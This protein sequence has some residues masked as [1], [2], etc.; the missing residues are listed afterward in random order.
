MPIFQ[1][2]LTNEGIVFSDETQQTSSANPVGRNRIINGQMRVAQRGAIAVPLT[3][4]TFGGCD[5]FPITATGFTTASGTLRQAGTV[6]AYVQEAQMTTTGSGIVRFHHRIEAANV[7]DLHDCYISAQVEVYQNTGAAVSVTLQLTSPSEFVDNWSSWGPVVYTGTPS[8]TVSVP[9]G[10]R[11]KIIHYLLLDEYN[12]LG[13]DTAKGLGITVSFP[14]GAVTS[15]FFQ[16]GNVQLEKGRY[17]T[18]LEYVPLTLEQMRCFRYYDEVVVTDRNYASGTTGI[19]G[20]VK[21]RQPMRATPTIART[22]GT[23]TNASSVVIDN[24]SAYG[25]TH[26]VVSS[27][28]GISGAQLETL[29]ISAE[30]L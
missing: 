11:T 30:L 3:T 21:W 5:R 14:V 6:G 18:E 12:V 10:V 26:R 13:T 1:T 20:P 17:P 7:K 15:K 29:K 25:A 19:S 16:I 23:L 28:S 9:S 2:Q 8:N 4:L 24:I 27:A 22:A